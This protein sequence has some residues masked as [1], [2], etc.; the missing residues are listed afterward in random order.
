MEQAEVNGVL[1]GIVS[2]ALVVVS[3]LPEGLQPV[4]FAKS[5]D[6]LTAVRRRGLEIGVAARAESPERSIRS[7]AKK[8][9][10]STGPKHLCERL[11]DQAFFDQLRTIEEVV[12]HL[13][14]GHARVV[15]SKHIATALARLIREGKLRREQNPDGRYAYQRV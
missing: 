3:D 5:F 1:K 14:L 7:G 6:Y 11:L 15:E 9:R 12:E 4:A 10:S 2:E 13:K 8:T